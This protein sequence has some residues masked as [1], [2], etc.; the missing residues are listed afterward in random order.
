MLKSD[1][2]VLQIGLD[3]IMRRHIQAFILV[4]VVVS[5]CPAQAVEKDDLCSQLNLENQQIEIQ[6]NLLD[7]NSIDWMSL[8]SR[9]MQ[10]QLQFIRIRCTAPTAKKTFVHS[11]TLIQEAKKHFD[12]ADKLFHACTTE[13]QECMSYE[14]ARL[15]MAIVYLDLLIWLGDDN[16]MEQAKQLIRS[17]R[18]IGSENV[19]LLLKTLIEQGV[20]PTSLEALLHEVVT[21][22]LKGESDQASTLQRILMAIR[23]HDVGFLKVLRAQVERLRRRDPQLMPEE[24]VT[25]LEKEIPDPKKITQLLF[26]LDEKKLAFLFDTSQ[27]IEQ[28]RR[29]A[30]LLE[31]R[32]K[33]GL[34]IAVSMSPSIQDNC[35]AATLFLR[36][37]EEALTPDPSP[38]LPVPIMVKTHDYESEIKE[39]LCCCGM[40]STCKNAQKTGPNQKS[41]CR[42]RACEAVLGM[43]LTEDSLGVRAEGT[44][45][46]VLP[47]SMPIGK[48]E[49]YR[50]RISNTQA[51]SCFD[52]AHEA[53]Y[54]V[55]ALEFLEDMRY[56]M[57][58]LA[59]LPVLLE[60][61]PLPNSKPPSAW[62]ALLLSGL[63]HLIDQST[64][65]D[66]QG[67]WFAMGDVV[68]TSAGMTLVGLS[69]H[70]RNE[71]SRGVGGLEVANTLLVSGSLALTAVLIGRIV[72]ALTYES[73]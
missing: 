22:L 41:N 57:D 31:D 72:S 51:F 53:G 2:L 39:L 61:C 3:Q 24:L 19:S 21:Q 55:A 32:Y 9:Y 49:S 27:A 4:L 68:L 67:W 30:A 71:Y 70:A 29:R 46:L 12:A 38:G 43:E 42:H 62:N 33:S 52:T 34:V 66:T 69:V 25:E 63:P 13:K 60:K 8:K 5:V 59:S 40:L 18:L 28:A 17:G 36:R 35:P 1:R 44:L 15:Q 10:N 26:E 56:K 58:V 64:D 54:A 45:Y 11:G 16:D 23:S 47:G 14:N 48:I 20:D 65:N 6:L 73:N 7:Q 50:R 37:I